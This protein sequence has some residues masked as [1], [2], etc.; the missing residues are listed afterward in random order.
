[1]NRR[2]RVYVIEHNAEGQLAH[3]IASVGARHDLLRGILKYDGE[4]LL[5]G[6]L[7]ERVIRAEAGAA[8]QA[9]AGAET[10]AEE[11]AR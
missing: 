3:L 10:P 7:A 9:G 8:A 4:P 2:R 5:P 6:E 11:A 1:M